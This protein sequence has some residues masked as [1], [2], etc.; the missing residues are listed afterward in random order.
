MVRTVVGFEWLVTETIAA[1]DRGVHGRRF[2]ASSLVA[3][4]CAAIGD[5]ELECPL[6]GSCDVRDCRPFIRLLMAA[7]CA[8]VGGSE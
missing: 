4:T 3:V 1:E 8:A 5:L 6:A 7:M 2:Q